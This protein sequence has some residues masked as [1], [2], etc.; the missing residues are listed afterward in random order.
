ML[1]EVSMNPVSYEQWMI[2]DGNWWFP[3][4]PNQ[5]C[6]PNVIS[7]LSKLLAASLKNTTK[8]CYKMRHLQIKQTSSQ[9]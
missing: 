5:L 7:E 4:Q 2:E 3:N 1:S 6:S 8:L 9:Q